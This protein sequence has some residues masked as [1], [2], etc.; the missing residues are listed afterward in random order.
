MSRRMS[1]VR[2]RDNGPEMAVRRLLHAAGLRYRVAWP[3]PGQ[4]RRTIDIAF[5][6]ARL[7]VFI[8][9]CFW[10]GCPTHGTRP[11]ANRDYWDAKIARN[12]ARD[13]RIDAALRVAGWRVVR[14][15]EHEAPE[16]AVGAIVAALRGD[17]PTR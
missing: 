11:R 12:R 1:A 7:A 13:M 16:E 9:G 6:K 15:W 8:D 10:H 5:T 14:L 2:K 3:V 4:R 17:D